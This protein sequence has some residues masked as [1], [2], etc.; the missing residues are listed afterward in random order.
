MHLR[1]GV[2]LSNRG[3]ALKKMLPP[4][5]LGLGGPLGDGSQYMSWITIDDTVGAIYHLLTHDELS[6]PFNIVSPNPVTNKEFTQALAQSLRRPAVLPVPL[7]AARLAFGEFAD[8][9]LYASNRIYPKR[10]LEA[11]YSFE[12]PSLTEAFSKLL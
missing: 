5:R 7:F 12:A 3:G 10:L 1:I 6:G 8:E 4:F 9:A 11:G 2:V